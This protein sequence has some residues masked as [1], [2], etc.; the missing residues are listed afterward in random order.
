MN[1]EYSIWEMMANGSETMVPDSTYLDPANAVSKAQRRARGHRADRRFG[2]VVPTHVIVRET[3]EGSAQ[4]FTHHVE[5][6]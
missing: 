1:R 4:N 6:V 5:A 2:K 3:R